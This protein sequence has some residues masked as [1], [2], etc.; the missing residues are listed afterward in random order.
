LHCLTLDHRIGPYCIDTS[1]YSGLFQFTPDGEAAVYA[2]RENGI[3]NL[4]VQSLDGSTGHQI[5]NFKSDQIEPDPPRE[6]TAE[7]SDWLEKKDCFGYSQVLVPRWFPGEK[8]ESLDLPVAVKCA[9]RR[10]WPADHYPDLPS[11]VLFLGNNPVDEWGYLPGAVTVRR[12]VALHSEAFG[13]LLAF[14]GFVSRVQKE[15][16]KRFA[17]PAAPVWLSER[18]K[19]DRRCA[20]LTNNGHRA[21]FVL[22]TH[23]S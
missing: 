11:L 9:P 5:T 7:A 21:S 18:Q 15:R 22:A 4:W 13:T 23:G 20:D 10:Q 19:R 2:T 17:K 14:D 16:R 8:K 12:D 1:H 6:I 3:D